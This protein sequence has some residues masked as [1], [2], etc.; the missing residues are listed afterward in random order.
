MKEKMAITT[1]KDHIGLLH[2]EVPHFEESRSVPVVRMKWIM[3]PSIILKF[4]LL[5]LDIVSRV[6]FRID[7]VGWYSHLKKTLY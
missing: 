5:H 3:I 6:A 7:I 2:E 1:I 4:F